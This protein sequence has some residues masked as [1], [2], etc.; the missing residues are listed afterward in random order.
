MS[1][2]EL[3]EFGLITGILVILV[4]GCA[5]PWLWEG[6]FWQ[7]WTLVLGGLFLSTGLLAPKMLEPVYNW[8]MRGAHVLGWINTRI[9]LS[10]CFIFIFVPVGIIMRVLGKTPLNKGFDLNTKSY[11]VAR[12]SAATNDMSKPF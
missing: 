5:L 10:V 8:W 6:R 12:I 9:I 2:K 7:M 1:V 3:R 11:K 4:F